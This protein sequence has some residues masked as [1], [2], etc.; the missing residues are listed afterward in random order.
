MSGEPKFLCDVNVGKLGRWLRILGFDAAFMNPER[1]EELIVL[2][3]KEDRIIL[4][5]DRGITSR[6][7]V[8]RSLLIESRDYHE[9]LREVI[10][11]FGL[12][13]DEARIFSRCLVCNVAVQSAAKGQ[14][15]TRVPHQAYSI[16]DQF[17]ECPT[18]RR[19]YWPGSHLTNTLDALREMGIF[20][21][22]D[23]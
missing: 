6:P 16:H 20:G 5:T 17:S 2:A 23:G 21:E 10:G 1:D 3:R 15:E 8:T 14:V 22:R 12:E 13:P 11:A 9:Q 19:V 4:T 7:Y 18:C